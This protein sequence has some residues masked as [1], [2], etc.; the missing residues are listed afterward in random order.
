LYTLFTEVT[1]AVFFILPGVTRAY[2]AV[3]FYQLG[4]INM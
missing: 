3:P 4:K 1:T 2:L